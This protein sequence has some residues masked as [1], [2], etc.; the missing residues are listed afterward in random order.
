MG[1]AGLTP[2]TGSGR[3]RPAG[4][5]GRSRSVCPVKG[6]AGAHS[7]TSTVQSRLS[8]PEIAELRELVEAAARHDGV[9]PLNEHAILHLRAGGGPHAQHVVARDSGRMVGYGLL[10]TADRSPGANGELVVAP[11]HRRRGLGTVLV[12]TMLAAVAPA[13]LRLWAHGD[14]PGAARLASSLGFSRVRDLWQ[15]RLDVATASLDPPPEL[16]PGVSVR[17]FVPGADDQVWLELNARAFAEHPEQGALTLPDLKARMGEPWFDPSGFFLAERDGHLVGFHWTKVH[18]GSTQHVHPPFGEV[19]VLGVDPSARGLGLGHAL[20][21]I[22]L[23]HLRDQ[24]LGEVM[25]YVDADNAAAIKTY[26]RLGFVHHSTDVMYC[27][28]G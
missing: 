5:G 10:D 19:Y 12:Q 26:Q 9:Y 14:Q 1:V 8:E 18:G 20:T 28:P 27:R 17:T 7:A 3:G 25:L 15:M 22:G 6:S 24:G 2:M 23:R 13:P 4:R 21:L 16:P 11:A